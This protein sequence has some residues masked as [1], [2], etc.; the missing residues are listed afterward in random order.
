M[1]FKT[2]VTSTGP[3]T[4]EA[5]YEGDITRLLIADAS[6]A[7]RMGLRMIF[8][9]D[10]TLEVSA[11]AGSADELEHLAIQSQPHVIVFDADMAGVER[12]VRFILRGLPTCRL[13]GLTMQTSSHFHNYVLGMGAVACIEKRASP[14]E[15]LE[16]VQ[17]A[18]SSLGR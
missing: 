2:D 4:M 7:L 13:I 10:N 6:T 8:G 14:M 16:A 18:R 1:L 5:V 17:A 3:S 9:L 11:E 15:L 12:A